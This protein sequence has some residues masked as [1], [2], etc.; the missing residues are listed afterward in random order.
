MKNYLLIILIIVLAGSFKAQTAVVKYFKDE[1][2][3]KEVAKEKARFSKTVIENPDGSITTDLRDLK[4]DEIIRSETY[5]GDE[6]YGVWKFN[7]GNGFKQLNYDFELNPK[8]FG[9]QD[10]I[11]GIGIKNYFENNDSL[12]YKAPIISSGETFYK[13]ISKNLFYPQKAKE[14]AI[15]GKVYLSFIITQTG[16]VE[17]VRVV[18]GVNIVLDKEAARFLRELKFSSPPTLNGIPQKVRVLLPLS[19]RLT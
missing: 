2:A 8:I 13:Y 1:F 19:F 11:P 5:K 7:Y 3:D 12:N 14:E 15:S 18:R 10:S 6:P 17:N 16:E 9:S 4:K